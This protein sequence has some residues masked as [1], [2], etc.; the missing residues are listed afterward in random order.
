MSDWTLREGDVLAELAKLGGES[1]S[2]V[3]TSPPYWSLRRYDAPV[4][5]WGGEPACPHDWNE[6][7]ISGE[8]YA[9][10]ARWQHSE[11]GRGEE[12]PA[13]KRLRHPVTRQARPEAWST[14]LGMRAKLA[15]WWAD[16]R[17]TEPETPEGQG[18]FPL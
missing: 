1:V 6:Q 7:A 11:N 14:S 15:Q 17:L 8:G 12:Q 2:C 3:V 4:V 18:A 16:T 9:G 10:T 5:S 13:E